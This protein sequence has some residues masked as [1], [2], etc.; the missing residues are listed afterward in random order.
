MFVVFLFLIIFANSPCG[1]VVFELRLT[2]HLTCLTISFLGFSSL[3]MHF[4]VVS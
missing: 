4:F 3:V 2:E 1:L